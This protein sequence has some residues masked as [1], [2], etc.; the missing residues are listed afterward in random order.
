MIMQ[1]FPPAAAVAQREPPTAI[2]AA[3]VPRRGSQYA[4]LMR[5]VKQA[6]LLD[7]RTSYYLWRIAV[8][9][10]VLAGGWLGF[11][12]VGESWW[13]LAVAALLAIAFGQVGF[14]AH[15]AGHKQIFASRRAND[16]AGM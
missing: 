2:A 16:T 13:Q 5:Q 3:S 11:V 8:T 1:T 12:L 4:A 6:G 7:R 14:L 15:E 10:A 9:T